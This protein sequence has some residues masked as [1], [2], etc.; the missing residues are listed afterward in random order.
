M[1]ATI[2]TLFI[3]IFIHFFIVGCIDI[4]N[5]IQND[6][7]EYQCSLDLSYTSRT[8]PVRYEVIDTNAPT[9]ILLHDKI[10]TPLDSNIDN[11]ARDFNYD[12]FTVVVPYLP[13]SNNIWDGDF[14]DG[15]SYINNLILQ[16]KARTNNNIILAGYGFGGT[17]ALA[18]SASLNTIRADL[19]N[20]LAPSHFIHQSGILADAHASSIELAKNMIENNQ[21][22]ET[23]SFYTYDNGN[24]TPITT[25]PEIYLSFHDTNEFPDIKTTTPL[26]LTDMLW[27]AGQDDPLTASA[28]SYGII[29]IIPAYQEYKE[30]PGDHTSLLT[31]VSDAFYTWYN[32]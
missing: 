30:I 7:Q 25:T 26:I 4:D 24:I 14:C 29:D 32:E 11:L 9:I 18:Y 3:L 2:K 12:G 16:E 10:E 17:F 21:S 1:R 27:L 19:L 15:I 28:K 13:W 8:N 22:Q 5:N 6:S 31:Y 23:D 20:I